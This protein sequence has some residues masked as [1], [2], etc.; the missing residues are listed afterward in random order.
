MTS[1]LPEL[2]P[3]K[4]GNQ[5]SRLLDDLP[6]IF[7]QPPESP[8]A[9]QPLPLGRFLM[10]FEAI[11]LG[12]PKN[13][14]D[15]WADLHHHP[16][17]EEILGG[18]TGSADKPEMSRTFSLGSVRGSSGSGE[19]EV[20]LEGIHRYFDPGPD[21][22]SHPK[23]LEDFNRTP[24]DFLAWLAGWVALTLR[25]DWKPEHKRK[26]I[27]NAVKLYKERGT[28]DGIKGF[29]EIYTGNQLVNIDDEDSSLKPFE[30]KVTVLTDLV[31][32]MNQR[33]TL[34]ALI[35]LQKPAHTS[36]RLD[37][38]DT[39]NFFTMFGSATE[40]TGTS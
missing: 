39:G 31:N 13:R 2:D 20:L 11:L 3:R 40:V 15:E 7:R 8:P 30:F 14:E 37:Y 38:A 16:G 34:T 4:S 5:L 6:A 33:D 18:A 10:A 35:E 29:V 22:E 21:Y 19:P 28:K 25:D 36:F 26:F 27:A 9:G 1:N 17:I 32:F 23:K 24:K 12:L